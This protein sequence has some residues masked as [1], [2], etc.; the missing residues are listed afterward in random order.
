MSRAESIGD[1]QKPR[2]VILAVSCF[3]G[4]DSDGM[5][6]RASIFGGS[7]GQG[8]RRGGPRSADHSDRLG[9]MTPDQLKKLEDVLEDSLIGPDERL[10]RII[11]KPRCASRLVCH[12]SYPPIK[13]NG[14]GN[15][16]VKSAVWDQPD[17][18]V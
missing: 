7:E 5:A 9:F 2:T 1:S 17:V 12:E 15:R 16:L 8:A 4:D 10:P 13:V 11:S 14:T 18:S 3:A 6:I